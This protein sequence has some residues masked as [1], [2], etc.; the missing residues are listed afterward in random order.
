MC[1]RRQ[2]RRENAQRIHQR[3]AIAECEA[4]RGFVDTQRVQPR[5]TERQCQASIGIRQRV[6]AQVDIGLEVQQRNGRSGALKKG[7]KVEPLECSLSFQRVSRRFDVNHAAAG[8]TARVTADLSRH[9]Q[10]GD[11]ALHGDRSRHRATQRHFRIRVAEHRERDRIGIQLHVVQHVLRFE[12]NSSATRGMRERCAGSI[13][14]PDVHVRNPDV[15]P[16]RIE[17]RRATHKAVQTREFL[18]EESRCAQISTL[19]V[20]VEPAESRERRIQNVHL[21]AA[22]PD[23]R[24]ARHVC[25]AER[26]AQLVHIEAMQR[27][28]L[29]FHGACKLPAPRIRKWN[30]VEFAKQRKIQRLRAYIHVSERHDRPADGP[31]HAPTQPRIETVR[32]HVRDGVSDHIQV[33]RIVANQQIG[34]ATTLFRKR[35]REP[36]DVLHRDAVAVQRDVIAHRQIAAPR[37]LANRMSTRSG[38]LKM[39]QC[40]PDRIAEPAHVAAQLVKPERRI[41]LGHAHVAD[42]EG[43]AG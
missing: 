28:T 13:V 24:C 31:R 25:I 37:D 19:D 40:E 3:D 26:E 27:A 32:V 6:A 12:R 5:A 8:H 42:G 2:R 38:Q 16:E 39:R 7:A 34:D 9:F 35:R 18:V 43:T 33:R 20:N 30:A 17:Q 36:R 21:T 22:A 10:R 41:V 4:R 14:V 15:I 1:D 23:A 11:G 29:R